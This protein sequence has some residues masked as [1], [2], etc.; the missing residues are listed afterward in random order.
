M[1]SLIAA[2]KAIGRQRSTKKHPENLR[3]TFRHELNEALIGRVVIVP[4]NQ[5]QWPWHPGEVSVVRE[6]QQSCG[7]ARRVAPW[8]HKTPRPGATAQSVLPTT[9]SR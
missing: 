9:A 1:A 5:H 7:F 3:G 8:S 6:R 4:Q 2:R